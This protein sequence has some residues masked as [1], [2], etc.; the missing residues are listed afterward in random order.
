M[1]CNTRQPELRPGDQRDSSRDRPLG[2]PPGHHQGPPAPPPAPVAGQPP[3]A[4]DYYAQGPYGAPPHGAAWSPGAPAAAGVPPGA[5]PPGQ[6][7]PHAQ[8]CP[9]R[10]Y[11]MEKPEAYRAFLAHIRHGID[12]VEVYLGNNMCQ[13]HHVEDLLACLESFLAR[14]LPRPWRIGRLD[15]ARNGLCDDS[16][17]RV[18]E[19]MKQW[20]LRV[21][22]LD[23]DSNAIGQ[24]GLTALVEY[25]WN[26]PEAISEIGLAGNGIEVSASSIGDDSVSG[27]LRC[28]YNHPI[29]PLKTQTEAGVHIVPF[30]LRLGDNKISG[31]QQLLDRIRDNG[32]V[33]HIRFCQEAAPY[34][35]NGEE[36]LSV[37][38]PFYERQGALAIPAGPAAIP[39]I[40]NSGAGEVAAAAVPAASAVSATSAA[41]AASAQSKELMGAEKASADDEGSE[42]SESQ[43]SQ[44]SASHGAV[45]P[46]RAEVAVAGTT[47]PAV[48]A[49]AVAPANDSASYSDE[50]SSEE[51]Q[52]AAPQ[53]DAAEVE[54]ADNEAADAEAPEE[55]DMWKALDVL[56][57]A[58]DAQIE[59]DKDRVA[60]L[61]PLLVPVQPAAEPE[62]EEGDS[63][64]SVDIK[65]DAHAEGGDI[66]VDPASPQPADPASPDPAPQASNMASPASS[67]SPKK[68]EEQPDNIGTSNSA[69]PDEEEPPKSARAAA[70]KRRARPP[71]RTAAEGK[72]KLCVLKIGHCATGK[73]TLVRDRFALLDCGF[74]VQGLLH[75]D[76]LH[77][78]RRTVSEGLVHGQVIDVEVCGIC[79]RRDRVSVR[80]ISAEGAAAG[81]REAPQGEKSDRDMDQDEAADEDA[82]KIRV[83]RRVRK[84]Q[85]RRNLLDKEARKKPN[86]KTDEPASASYVPSASGKAKSKPKRRAEDP[87]GPDASPS[88]A[89]SFGDVIGEALTD[90]EQKHLQ[91]DMIAHLDTMT[92]LKMEAEDKTELA[93]LVNGL[94]LD[95]KQPSEVEAELTELLESHASPF[96]EW[97]VEH[98]KGPWLRAVRSRAG[99]TPKSAAKK[100]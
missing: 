74:D 38:L 49:D 23:L 37:C 1:K 25:I 80:Q 46:D 9:P 31:I 92:E 13:D 97:F 35:P 47:Q 77:G 78:E 84:S 76:S 19:R 20:S 7:H 73:V 96:M 62:Q 93:E 8:Q 3:P 69:A 60:R 28:L 40:E 79:T 44:S 67:S 81:S 90:D 88:I 43:Y 82:P 15:L 30:I 63:D 59:K 39:P 61:S 34:A 10:D 45:E 54:E 5:A 33:A 66:P 26:C 36:Y 86:G 91:R 57:A 52:R 53:G 21:K 12:G 56:E 58:A 89:D 87:I 27:L 48:S 18:V 55:D 32:G 85:K 2:P 64:E 95:G 14:T 94:L 17:W 24:K 50:E 29:Y 16:V 70:S 68:V 65:S 11:A 22:S 75:I 4:Y 71:D 42:S 99:A 100:S 83:K 98:V 72:I 51:E 6:W 41:P